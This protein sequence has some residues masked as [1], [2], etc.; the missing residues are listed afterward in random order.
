MLFSLGGAIFCALKG[1]VMR[2]C[3]DV[4]R[5]CCPR[6]RWADTVEKLQISDVVIFR[7]EPAIPKSQMRSAM[8]RSELAHERQKTNLAEP[9]T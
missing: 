8:R 7:K 4:L 6:S 5:R 1:W 3:G 9:L 2:V